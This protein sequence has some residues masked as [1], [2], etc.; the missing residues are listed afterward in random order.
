MQILVIFAGFYLSP[1][2]L[3]RDSHFPSSLLPANMKIKCSCIKDDLH[4]SFTFEDPAKIV[5]KDSVLEDI[6]LLL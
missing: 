6:K 5:N 2:G 1:T 3:P 4:S